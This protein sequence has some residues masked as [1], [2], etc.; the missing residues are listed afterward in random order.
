MEQPSLKD[1]GQKEEARASHIP[2]RS[3]RLGGR[4]ASPGAQAVQDPAWVQKRD[5]S[6]MEPRICLGVSNARWENPKL[7]LFCSPWGH[8]PRESHP[9]LRLLCSGEPRFPNGSE[10]CSEWE[11]APQQG[12]AVSSPAEPV[13]ELNLW[14]WE[15]KGRPGH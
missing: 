1:R 10:E 11:P 3:L 5:G 14:Y 6:G 4:S 9:A 13:L 8:H 15:R 7:H 2:V 12:A